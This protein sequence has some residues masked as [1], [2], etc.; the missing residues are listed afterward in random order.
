MRNEGNILDM[1]PV[2]LDSPTGYPILGPRGKGMI[3]TIPARI[4]GWV[5]GC[6]RVRRAQRLTLSLR[7]GGEIGRG[8]LANQ[9]LKSANKERMQAFLPILNGQSK[10]SVFGHDLKRDGGDETHILIAG[11]FDNL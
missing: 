1:Y 6:M 7:P 9:G 3:N 10:I 11:D 8:E 5:E 4:L 2:D